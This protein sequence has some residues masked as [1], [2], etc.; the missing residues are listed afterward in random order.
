MGEV[1]KLPGF[2]KR[3]PDAMLGCAKAADL[4]SVT[5]IGWNDGVIFISSSHEHREDML[6]DLKQAEI[7][8]LSE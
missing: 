8:V 6:W 5:I 2:G 4:E 7:V 3:N 1:H